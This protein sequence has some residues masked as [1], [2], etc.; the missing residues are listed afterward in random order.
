MRFEDYPR[1]NVTVDFVVFT[2]QDKRLKVLLIK[3]G[4]EPFKDKWALPGGFVK[5]D[6]SLE[7]CAKRELKEE[8]GV[9]TVYLEQLY[10]FGY[11][12]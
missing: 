8:A 3:R 10:T 12:K 2:I 6:E 1:P 4:V 11:Y 5:L 9:D 7:D